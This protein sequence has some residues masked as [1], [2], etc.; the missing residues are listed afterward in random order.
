MDQTI[1]P[2]QVASFKQI[3]EIGEEARLKQLNLDFDAKLNSRVSIGAAYS[4]RG[5]NVPWDMILKEDLSEKI[6]NDITKV[7]LHWKPT[8]RLGLSTAY[9][10]DN[11]S[12][13]IFS[14]Q[15]LKTKRL[16]IGINYY[17]PSGFFLK[18]EII[19]ID[20]NI[21]RKL[22]KHDQDEIFNYY[23]AAYNADDLA[24]PRYWPERQLFL[25]VSVSNLF[26]TPSHC[27]D[28]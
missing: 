23:D 5:L 25:R 13:S 10:S 6:E 8:E 7:Y 19:H 26:I 20:Q 12:G 3:Y 11:F 17:S 28:V 16:P 15:A 22:I 1:E 4:L 9:E 21:T 14:P 24:N 18:A 27:N 2:T